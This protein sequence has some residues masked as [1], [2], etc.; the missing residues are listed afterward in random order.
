MKAL[1]FVILSIL[2]AIMM[3]NAIPTGNSVQANDNF[4]SIENYSKGEVKTE[5]I[6][7]NQILQ[8]RNSK[9][10]TNQ[11]FSSSEK[12]STPMF[13]NPPFIFLDNKSGIISIGVH[14]FWQDQYKSCST[15]FKC[16]SNTTTGWK[17]DKSFQ[18][19][20]S[21]S[22]NNTWSSVQSQQMYVNPGDQYQ[23]VSHMKLNQWATQ[24]HIVLEG[25]NETS[26]GWYRIAHCP[27]GVNGP[28]EWQEFS[29]TV[30]IPEKTTK[31]REVLKAGWSSDPEREATTW[32]D[33]IDLLG[34]ARTA[35]INTDNLLKNH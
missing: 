26:K 10:E 18:L 14:S 21:N 7:I 31:I 12:Y 17:S 24:S 33:S 9:S 34:N 25:Y 23:L 27:S 16:I 1:H 22:T 20:T 6:D 8:A 4:K 30:T 35:A 32:F 15:N 2:I 28:L 13:S 29:C 3:L 11:N 19:S 5:D